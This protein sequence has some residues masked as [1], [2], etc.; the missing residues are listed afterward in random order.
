MANPNTGEWVEDVNKTKKE[1]Q[2]SKLFKAQEDYISSELENDPSFT[3]KDI[4]LFQ[5][6]VNFTSNSSYYNDLS[7]EMVEYSDEQKA[8]IIRQIQAKILKERVVVDSN[9][10]TALRSFDL[11][12]TMSTDQKNSTRDALT[13]SRT[14]KVKQI[15]S[16]DSLKVDFLK[17]NKILTKEE[18]AS[19]RKEEDPLDYEQLIQWVNTDSLT[20][21]QQQAIRKF[22]QEKNSLNQVDIHELLSIFDDNK[23][24]EILKDFNQFFSLWDL[25]SYGI[26]SQK[27][28]KEYISTAI[29]SKIREQWLWEELHDEIFRDSTDFTDI[30]IH[31][32]DLSSQNIEKV[33]QSS[34]IL[35]KIVHEVNQ[36]KEGI[37]KEIYWEFYANVTPSWPNEDIHD[38]FID[39]IASDLNRW[40]IDPKV[41]SSIHNLKSWGYIRLSQSWESNVNEW[42]YKISAVDVWTSF[43]MKTLKLKNIG[44]KWWV[45]KES[46]VSDE[47]HS[48]KSLYDLFI[49][50]GQQKDSTIE[51]L[52]E[53]DFSKLELTEIVKWNVE[54]IS[55]LKAKLDICDP[56]GKDVPLEAGKMSIMDTSINPCQSFQV[57]AVDDTSITLS[58]PGW[59][60]RVLSLN[61]FYDAFEDKKDKAKR[62]PTLNS[63]SWF[64]DLCSSKW[65]ED[66]SKIALHEEGD[67]LVLSWEKSK[68]AKDVSEIKYFIGED[69]DAIYIKNISE[70]SIEYTLWKMEEWQWKTWK[71]KLFKWK[72]KSSSFDDF[73][74]DIKNYKMLPD[75]TQAYKNMKHES[76]EAEVKG[77][78][79]GKWLNCLSI[80]DISAWGTQIIDWFKQSFERWDKLKAAKF[81]HALSKWIPMTENM[82]LELKMHKEKIEKDTIQEMIDSMKSMGSHDLIKKVRWIIL[83]K[84]SQEYQIIACMFTVAEKYWDLYPKWLADLQNTQVWFKRLGWER[85]PDIIP[86]VR[87]AVDNPDKSTSWKSE[88]IN[89]TEDELIFEL[90]TKRAK[91]W[92]L[93]S[94]INKDY[95]K[96]LNVGIEDEMKDGEEKV[97]EQFTTQWKI[98]HVVWELA[99]RGFPNAIGWM[100]KLFKKYGDPVGMQACPFIFTFAGSWPELLWPLKSKILGLTL[101]TPYASLWFALSKEHTN[102]YQQTI[103]RAL[104]KKQHPAAWELESILSMP[105][106]E[107][108]DKLSKFWAKYGRELVDIINFNDPYIFLHKDEEPLFAEFYDVMNLYLGHDEAKVD[109]DEL[110]AWV[111][112][113]NT[114]VFAW[115]YDEV[116]KSQWGWL[117]LVRW[118]QW[119]GFWNEGWQ[120]ITEMYFVYLKKLKDNPNLSEQE[121]KKVFFEVF[122]KIE[123]ALRLGLRWDANEA[124]TKYSWAPL[125][126]AVLQN[127]LDLFRWPWTEARVW[128]HLYD[129]FLENTWNKFKSWGNSNVTDWLRTQTAVNFNDILNP[130]NS[131]WEPNW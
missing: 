36:E 48:Y 81:W 92:T 103:I 3:W 63:F 38:S 27:E 23:K 119:Y 28:V 22:T 60:P 53:W 118:D 76:E 4:D 58:S 113:S 62:I 17:K 25:V 97:A 96:A 124:F 54:S 52:S 89:F 85:Y 57:N 129:T 67:K 5:K 73:F 112:T 95:R 37:R 93:R 8:N 109:K 111:Y 116:G 83:N 21:S 126:G 20:S 123:N 128:K 61:E 49:A 106:K 11:M 56:D 125:P 16:S 105:Y 114:T 1:N 86:K 131:N 30:M 44:E 45:R 108:P 64:L 94:K 51:I 34:K 91:D 74:V 24:V 101:S 50:D 15:I 39:F 127:N 13:K 99:N 12:F 130:A 19:Q 117:E 9:I 70:D 46:E 43:D 26:L 69:G 80:T 55:D 6:F 82:H 104:K 29:K 33:L 77:S 42:Y 35:S 120:K 2:V 84:E 107:R 41:I 102:L 100:E 122:P 87:K 18:I 68:P 78:I 75:T 71:D 14:K 31:I 32:D 88:S 110:E 66:I 121:K 40:K 115:S 72:Y 79:F 59:W 90:L 65:I 7:T 10:K 47:F 98:D